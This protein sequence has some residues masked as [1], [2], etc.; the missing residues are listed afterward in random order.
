MEEQSLHQAI[1]DAINSVMGPKEE[2]VQRIADAFVQEVVALPDSTITLGEIKR[3]LEELEAEFNG[4]LAQTPDGELEAYMNRF[5]A[6]KDEMTPLK[7]Q[8]EKISA[9]LR[10]NMDVQERVRKTMMAL[11]QADHHMTQWNEET[12]RQL[13]HTVKVV[14]A[15]QIKV[16]LYDGTEVMR[17]GNCHR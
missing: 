17:Q 6:I 5:Q 12:I 16:T 9:Q 10:K 14:D 4:M 15:D 3:R 11:D 7:E 8:R 1:M 2:L 13:V